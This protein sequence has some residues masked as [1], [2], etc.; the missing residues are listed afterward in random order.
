MSEV[1]CRPE[2]LTCRWIKEMTEAISNICPT[3]KRIIKCIDKE[4]QWNDY[5]SKL[6]K[7]E[8]IN[9]QNISNILN[10]SIDY[11]DFRK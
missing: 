1:F 2:K 6:Q 3:Q 4:K 8:C 11:N 5:Y 7:T 9:Y 10:G